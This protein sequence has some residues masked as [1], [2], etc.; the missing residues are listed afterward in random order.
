MRLLLFSLLFAST[1]L[2]AQQTYVP[3]NIFEAFLESNGM[4]NGVANDDYVTTAN[5]SGVGSLICWGYG[6]SDLTG[7]EDFTALSMLFCFDN[8]LTT[9]DVSQN[10]FL[11]DFRCN[12]NQLT[13]LNISTNANLSQLFCYN[14][15]L[16]SLNISACTNLTD[17]RCQNNLISSINPSTCPDLIRLLCNNNQLTTL[18]V[19][20]NPVLYDLRCNNN[21]LTSINV[22]QNPALASLFCYYNQLTTLDVSQNTSLTFLHCYDNLLSNL[23]IN[24]ITSLVNFMC[25]NNQ[26]TS[27]DVSQQPNLTALNCSGNQLA[28]L[29]A[30][31]GQDITLDCSN[32]PISCASVTYPPWAYANATYD[33]GI[34]FVID[35]QLPMN[36]DLT[37]NG[38]VLSAVQSGASYQ[39]LDCDNGHAPLSNKIFQSFTPGSTGNYACEVTYTNC[40]GTQVDTSM[41]IYVD[42]QSY[43]NNDVLQTG[44]TLIAEFG[45]ISYQW[46]DC[47]ANYSPIPGATNQAFTA[48]NEGNYAVKIA[49]SD[50]CEGFL[51]D[52]SSCHQVAFVDLQELSGGEVE[53][54]KI[55]DLL[56]R[57]TH[58]KPNTPL[59][60][61]YSNGKME[62]VFK[63]EE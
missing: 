44:A 14:N 26:L 53:L 12:N 57:E 29:T 17:L 1:A 10:L 52:T 58:F 42:C 11:S 2:H 20:G 49:F 8:N 15:L 31:N 61:I 40:F 39:W 9:L 38:V 41:C 30:N 13:S 32:N 18:S 28:C 35:C 25:Y 50:L 54:I 62:R 46:L 45:G 34:N 56:G 37:Q 4:G 23:T 33:P 21:Q 27:L 7:I 59:I 36:N 19:T 63:L 43:I 16:T 3:D 6:I 5:I 48:T 22:T 24:P 60:Y 47:N 55:V 51:S